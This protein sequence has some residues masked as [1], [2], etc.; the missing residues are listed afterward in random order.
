MNKEPNLFKRAYGKMNRMKT[1]IEKLNRMK[2]ANETPDRMK[3]AYGNPHNT[4]SNENSAQKAK[5]I[6]IDQLQIK[7]KSI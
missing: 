4:K 6:L 7:Y 5:L 3:T 1:G 2:I